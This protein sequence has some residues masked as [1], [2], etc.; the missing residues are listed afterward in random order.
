[1]LASVQELIPCI[2]AGGAG[3]RLWP[4]SRQ[5]FP[6]PFIRL[7][8][9]QSLLQ[10]TFLRAARLPG[11]KRVLIVTNR[12]TMFRTLDEC[13][14]VNAGCLPLELLL[15][16]TGRN[17]A[18]ALAAAVADLFER[19]PTSNPLLLALPAD[20]LI[21]DEDAFVSAVEQATRLAA[22]GSI[23]TFGL[24]PTRP[25]TGFGYILAGE[26][27]GED[28]RH[29]VGFVE[30]PDLITAQRY[31][32][33]GEYLW[34]SGMFCFAAATMRE[35]LEEHAPDVLDA[36]QDCLAQSPV[37]SGEGRRLRE[38]HHERFARCPDISIDYAVM[39]RAS[40]VAVVPCELGWSDIGNW[41]S[42]A[43]QFPS[44]EDGNRTSGDVLVHDSRDCF[45]HS[46]ER[47]V[48]ALGLENLIVVDTPDALLVAD[49]SRSQD[50]R[51]VTRQLQQ[52][53]HP[54]HRQHMSSQRP[55]GYYNVL[56]DCERYKIKRLVV[57]Y[58]NGE[59]IVVDGGLTI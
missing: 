15:E 27:I 8:G 36:V 41:D 13:Q 56:A 49:R 9:D 34:N 6:K 58:T 26:A 46:S 7:A 55:W 30:K 35:A 48:A 4:V 19:D 24:K 17:T 52:R 1:M 18:P 10:K 29:V 14:A 47:L 39:E 16:P 12:Q 44:D 3:T 43:E 45:V 5:E 23:V 11:V 53:D 20:H 21:T 28:G 25:E 51:E 59:C 22:L 2:M 32:T 57:S 31:V 54:T 33:S 42:V 50:V 38:F 40:S 37:L